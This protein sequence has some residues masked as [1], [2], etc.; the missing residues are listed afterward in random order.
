MELKEVDNRLLD[1]IDKTPLEQDEE[2][3]VLSKESGKP[4]KRL[5]EQL[6]ILTKNKKSNDRQLSK[7]AGSEFTEKQFYTLKKYA[8]KDNLM[9]QQAIEQG[10]DFINMNE[11]VRAQCKT[12]LKAIYS[13]RSN[14]AS[15]KEQVLSLLHRKAF[16]EATEIL[17]QEI[18]KSKSIYTTK[19][20]KVPEVFIFHE[21][22]YVDNGES[23]IKELLRDMM[24]EDY[25]EWLANQ[26]MAKIRADSFIEPELFFKE[27]SSFEI[28]LLNGIL[29]LQT[30][31]LN[32]F[33]PSKI[34]FSKLPVFYDKNASCPMV[35]KFL[36]EVLSCPEDK[37]VFYE[38]AGFGLIKNYFMEKA[39]M[40]VGN[41]RNGKTK[42][43]ELLKR[44]V[45]INNCAS[46]PLSS[47]D[48]NSPFVHKLWKRFFNCAGDINS[49]D[50]KDTAMFKQL[51]GGDSISANIKFKNVIEFHNYAKLVFA[52]NE[53]PRVYDYSDGFWERWVLLEF[54]YKFVEQSVYDSSSEEE[55]K[56]FK[57]KDPQ[58]IDKITTPE[59]MSGFLNQ[60]I[61]GLHRLLKNKKFSYTKGCI[62][63]KNKWIRKA[64]SFM[65]FCM[66][67]LEGDYDSRVSK[68]ELRRVYKEY[69]TKHK[70][71][72]V[73]DKAIKATLQETFGSSD[74]YAL[75]GDAQEYVWTGIKLKKLEESQKV[76]RV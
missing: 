19:T 36:T 51:T 75:I 8:S 29:D 52:C 25:S 17:V 38:L 66:D 21:G 60:A 46:V 41:G 3:E 48:S 18:Q 68:K 20:D 49:K 6:K 45:G 34:F 73:S 44:L 31:Q 7:E 59:E 54:P 63:V 22:I 30:L 16:G 69:C 4:V 13:G 24:E 33:K 70:V 12:F 27:S 14:N 28:P 5:A 9:L 42:S 10:I 53:L 71:V 37:D 11:L 72:G 64:D 35:D 57:I 23:Q 67:C 62:E 39:F 50:L 65:A 26:V 32:D 43:I 56:M 74:E 15:M 47:I 40:L 76:L 1:I 55:R 58:I 61:L 2:L